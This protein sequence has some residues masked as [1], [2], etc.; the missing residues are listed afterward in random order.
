MQKQLFSIPEARAYLEH[1]IGRDSLYDLAHGGKVPVVWIGR[2]KLFFPKE[3]LDRILAGEIK[4][5]VKR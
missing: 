2:S 5:E 3:T 1:R 4:I